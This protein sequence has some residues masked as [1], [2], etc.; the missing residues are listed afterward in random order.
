MWRIGFTQILHRLKIVGD[1]L[2]LLD[3]ILVILIVIFTGV[4]C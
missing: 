3:E 4:E 1:R 2:W